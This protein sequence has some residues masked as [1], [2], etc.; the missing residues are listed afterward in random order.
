M[1]EAAGSTGV[2]KQVSGL[3]KC[4]A[5]AWMN[6]FLKLFGFVTYS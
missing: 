2:S 6:N 5:Y 1:I 4:Q 3:Y